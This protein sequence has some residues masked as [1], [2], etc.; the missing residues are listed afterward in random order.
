MLEPKVFHTCMHRRILQTTTGCQVTEELRRG[1]LLTVN[2][3]GH[4]C[5]LARLE[6]VRD[7]Q[8]TMEAKKEKP[9]VAKR[10]R[11][12]QETEGTAKDQRMNICISLSGVTFAV[13]MFLLCSRC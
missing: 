7:H 3:L 8:Q 4:L 10:G 5:V 12:Q 2:P 9:R 13:V 11:Q 1:F 6:D